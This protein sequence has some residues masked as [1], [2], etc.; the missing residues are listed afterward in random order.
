MKDRITYV[1]LGVHK[2]GIVVAI[3]EGACGA[4]FGITAGSR[5]RRRLCSSWWASWPSRVE[6]R[7]YY[8]DGVIPAHAVAA[9]A[10]LTEC[11]NERKRVPAVT[12]FTGC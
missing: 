3:A 4:R 7:F 10:H 5:T 1:G 12:G 9:H 6:L 8:E 11:R 2:D